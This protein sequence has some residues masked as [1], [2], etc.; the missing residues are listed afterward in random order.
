MKATLGALL[1]M[2]LLGLLPALAQPLPSDSIVPAGPS[3][4][5]DAAFTLVIEAPDDVRE[6]LERNLDVLRYRDVSDLSDGELAR[7]LLAAEQDAR[8]LVATMGYFS[9][10][11]TIEPPVSA[12]GAV[13]RKL[14]LRVVPGDPT[15]VRDVQITFLG[16]ILSDSATAAQRLRIIR[17]WPLET[18]MRFSQTRWADAKKHAVLQ[19][20]AQSYPTA[21]ITESE[22]DIDPLTRSARLSITLDS[23][24]RYRLGPLVITGLN[25]FDNDMVRR[26]M[27]LAPGDYDQTL[28]VA[29]QR[30]LTDS[31]YFDSAF[32]SIDTTGDPAAAPVLVQVREAKLQKLVL[33]VGAS[34]DTGARLSIE[35]THHKIPYL[36]WRGVNKLVLARD[37]SSLTSDFT[38]HPNDDNWRWSVGTV[39][40]QQSLGSFLVHSQSVRVGRSRNTEPLD[41]AYYL[42]YDRADAATSDASAQAVVEALTANYAFT[43]RRFDHPLFPN[44]GWGLGLAVGAGTTVGTTSNPYS[45]LLARGLGYLPLTNAG[46]RIAV[47]AQAGAIVA[48]PSAEL[49]STQLFFLGGDNTVRG[50]G[51]QDLGVPLPDGQITGGRYMAVG[52]VEWQRPIRIGGRPSDWESTLFLDVGSVANNSTELRPRYGLGAGARWKSPVGPLQIDVAYGVD[53]QRFR[54]HMNVGFSF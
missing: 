36:D 48:E 37:L 9:P 14:K 50:Y 2:G 32:I 54:L 20:T 21:R 7:L 28:L 15:E 27:R 22:A 39:I 18:G 40:Q 52:S 3:T 12:S 33:G 30:R 31:G 41:N 10:A 29:A 51:Y 25:H 4:K 23:G 26:L 46:G 13:S 35:H 43:V 17:D 45:R 6:M 49:P 34:T 5:A 47:R 53:V 44:A 16:P 42:E 11:I 38:S 1:L 24:P 19:L 8:E